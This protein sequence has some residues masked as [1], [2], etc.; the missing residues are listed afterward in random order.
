[1]GALAT[2]CV[3]VAGLQFRRKGERRYGNVLLALSLAMTAVVAWGAGPRLHLIP[4][5]V[6]LAVV[7]LVALAIAALAT[8]DDSEF[9]FVV[10]VAGALSAPF[11]MA[12][13]TGRPDILLAY[14]VVVLLGG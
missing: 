11:I 4:S 14:G 12:D 13:N 1:A 3:A 10:A 2:A 9:L 6:A 5:T 7:D 8:Q